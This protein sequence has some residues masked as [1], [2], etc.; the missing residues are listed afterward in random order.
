MGRHS[1]ISHHLRG[2]PF[3]LGS[4]ERDGL[5]TVP[6]EIINQ[7]ESTN[8]QSDWRLEDAFKQ[9]QQDFHSLQ[10]FTRCPFVQNDERREWQRGW[11]VEQLDVVGITR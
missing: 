2:G 6:Q 10:L 3:D 11:I 8:D 5:M 4:F 7:V 1:R 9:G